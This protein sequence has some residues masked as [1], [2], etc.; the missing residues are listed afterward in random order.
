[1][2]S[3]GDEA[4]SVRVG[5][6]LFALDIMSVREIR[7]WTASTP[8]PHAPPY[9]LG[10]INLRGLVL[11]VFDL[12]G[13][14]GLAAGIPDASSVVVV[15]DVGDRQVGLVVEAV[16]DILIVGADMLQPAPDVGGAETR[17]LVQGVLTLKEGIVTILSLTDLVPEMALAA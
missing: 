14:L 1:M 6:Q 2:L 17:S 10:M 8:L 11:P 4:I 16:C 7:G 5:G 9:V 13:R 3:V 15:V 12:A